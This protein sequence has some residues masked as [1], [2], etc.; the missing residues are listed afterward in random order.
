MNPF[1]Y[2]HDRIA[3][4]AKGFKK[5]STVSPA[6]VYASLIPKPDKYNTEHNKHLLGKISSL[7]NIGVGNIHTS[8]LADIEGGHRGVWKPAKDIFGLPANH[9]TEDSANRESAAYHVANHLGFGDLVP[10]TVIRDHEGTKGS[11]QHLVPDAMQAFEYSDNY[12]SNKEDVTRSAIFDYITGQDD[13]HE[14]NWLLT[15]GEPV[16]EEEYFKGCKSP[17]RGDKI[18]LIDNGFSFPNDY[19]PGIVRQGQLLKKVSGD[20]VPDLS[21]LAEKWANIEEVLKDHG[22]SQEAIDLTKERFNNILG[23]SKSKMKFG[24]LPFGKGKVREVF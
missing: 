20:Y 24:D 17:Y 23:A 11:M 22:I 2:Y 9:Q 10:H 15:H 8:N 7:S 16:S 12:G 18:Q 14:G 21:H 6:K 3:K 13:R 5:A 19:G 1:H 4:Y